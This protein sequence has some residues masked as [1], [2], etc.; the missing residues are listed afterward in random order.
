MYLFYFLEEAVF[1]QKKT[2]CFNMNDYDDATFPA[3]YKVL[4]F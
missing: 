2:L 1:L 4:V 3:K